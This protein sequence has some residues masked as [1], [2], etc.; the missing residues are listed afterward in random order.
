[1]RIRPYK[2]PMV[3][4]LLTLNA[5]ICVALIVLILLQRSDTGSGGVFGGTGSAGPVVRNPMAKPTAILAALF[6]LFSLLTAV[7]NKGGGHAETIM[8]DSVAAA[9]PTL[10]E[11]SLIPTVSATTAPASTPVI[12]TPSTPSPTN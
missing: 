8:T 7:L 5:I 9:A 1:M 12:T 2:P 6:L 3:S 11:A 10:P 4:I